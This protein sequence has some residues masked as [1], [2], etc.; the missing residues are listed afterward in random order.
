MSTVYVQACE[1]ENITAQGTCTVPVWVH[2]PDQVFPVLT[3]GEGTAVA[4][5]IVSVWTAGAI[6]RMYSRMAKQPF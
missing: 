5:S 1:A 6:F 4:F 3:L 2:K